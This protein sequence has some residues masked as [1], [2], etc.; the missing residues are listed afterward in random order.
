VDARRPRLRRIG[1][2]GLAAVLVVSAG[3]A[4]R[5]STTRLEGRTAR[6]ELSLGELRRTDERLAAEVARLASEMGALEAAVRDAVSQAAAMRSALDALAARA[7]EPG[8]V[9]GRP[10]STGADL[11]AP[12]PTEPERV[13]RGLASGVERPAASHSHGGPPTTGADLAAPAT[14]HAEYAAALATF[15]AREH[16]QAVLDFLAFIARHPD[17]PRAATAQFWIGEAYFAQRDYRQALVEFEKV[18]GRHGPNASAPE[19]LWKI[20]LCHANLRESARAR[21]TWRRLVHEYPA[22]DAA[23]RARA[24]LATPGGTLAR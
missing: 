15:H 9:S 1:L 11:A 7:T 8:R 6:L 2:A 22:S 21:D 14:A 3:C 17:H 18:L 5:A 24:R 19:S 10:S 23:Q 13:S 20:G 4:T 16:G 12:A